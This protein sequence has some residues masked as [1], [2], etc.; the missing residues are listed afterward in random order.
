MTQHIT[1]DDEDFKC[2]VRGGIITVNENL[3]IAL[4]DIGFDKMYEAI[5]SAEQRIDIYKGHAK[6]NHD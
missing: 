5:E 3:Q 4:Q 6:G 2:L 1:L